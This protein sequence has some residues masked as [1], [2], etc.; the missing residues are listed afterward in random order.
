ML[1]NSNK[2]NIEQER[3]IYETIKDDMKEIPFLIWLSNAKIIVSENKVFVILE[4]E[5]K[6]NTVKNALS[7]EI[8]NAVIKVL[9]TK[10]TVYY[11]Y[12]GENGKAKII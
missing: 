9:K 8:Q 1:E 10:R 3:K 12:I 5:F 2:Q 4:N 7:N 11:A 6:A